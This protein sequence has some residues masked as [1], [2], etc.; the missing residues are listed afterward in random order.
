ML[1]DLL[2]KQDQARF[3]KVLLLTVKVPQA[4]DGL[5]R[6]VKAVGDHTLY[7]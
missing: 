4:D 3:D 1:I 5:S 7:L 6:I 2:R